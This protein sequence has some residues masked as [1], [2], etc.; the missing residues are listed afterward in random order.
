MRP[1]Y[2]NIRALPRTDLLIS[3]LL[4]VSKEVVVHNY[5][6]SNQLMV[7]MW[8]LILIEVLP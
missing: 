5:D 1:C 3:A 7:N 6:L 8:S 2:F 4:I